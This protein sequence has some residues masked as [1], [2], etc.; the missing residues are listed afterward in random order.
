MD[1]FIKRITERLSDKSPRRGFF[2]KAG[3]I[4]LGAAA[5]ITGQGIFTKVAEAAPY[6]CTGAI[7]CGIGH[8]PTGTSVQ[9]TWTCGHPHDH[10]AGDYYICHDCYQLYPYRLVCVYA[11]THD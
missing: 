9:Y 4:A 2:A 3:K 7:S 1:E 8:C 5:I 10:D 6:C 11:T